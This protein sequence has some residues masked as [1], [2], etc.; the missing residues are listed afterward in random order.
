MGFRRKGFAVSFPKFLRKSAL[1]LSFWRI[2]AFSAENRVVLFM[3]HE[4]VSKKNN[5]AQTWHFWEEL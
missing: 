4:P 1:V 5:F 2:I 3:V